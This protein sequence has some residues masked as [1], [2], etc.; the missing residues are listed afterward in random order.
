RR[1]DGGHRGSDQAEG[2]HLEAPDGSCL[3]RAQQGHDGQAA[4]DL[5]AG[6]AARRWRLHDSGGQAATLPPTTRLTREPRTYRRHIHLS[7]GSRVM[8]ITL[9]PKLKKEYETLFAT[10]VINPSKQAAVD[11]IRKKIVDNRHRYEEVEGVTGVPWYVVAVIH[12]LEGSLNFKTHLH[13]GDPLTAKTVHVPKGRPPGTPPFR[14]EDSAVD[15]LKFDNMTGVRKWTLAVILFKL[16]GFNGF[17][18]RTRHPEVLT[19]YLWSFSNHYTKGKFTG[20]RKFDPNA[21][22][23]QCGAAVILQSLS[24][25][26]IIDSPL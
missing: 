1:D 22:S 17:G 15:A 8:A 16:E 6:G 2:L 7:I 26:K 21:V 4:S 18:Y 12:S 9:T 23:K 11:T 10:C 19:P 20:D 25:E 24:A 5:Q 3:R 13:N 14:W